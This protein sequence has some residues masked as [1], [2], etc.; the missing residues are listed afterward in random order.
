L[1]V[2]VAPRS[3]VAVGLYPL[4]ATRRLRTSTMIK[5]RITRPAIAPTISA[6]GNQPI[7][8]RLTGNI[9]P[10]SVPLSATTPSS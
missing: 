3:V 1:A 5:P 9:D 8:V 4:A 7:L 10:F 2:V 6:I